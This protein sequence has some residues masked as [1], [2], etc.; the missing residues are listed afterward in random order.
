M[1]TEL[2]VP[3]GQN[4]QGILV[5]AA[6]AVRQTDYFCPQCGTP[7]V[8]RAGE[9]VIRHFAHKANTSC[10]GETIA[11]QTAKR[12]LVQIISEYSSPSC[13]KTISLSCPCSCCRKTTYLKLPSSSFTTAREE[14]RIGEFICDVVAFRDMEPVLGIEVLATHAVDEIK[15]DA[16]QIP[17]VELLAEKV[18]ENPYDWRPVAARLKEVTCIDCKN[19]I[20]KL[21][22]LANQWS[23]AF[24]E[25]ARSRSPLKDTY[26]AAIETCWKCRN[27]IL[28]YWWQGVPF[29][30]AEPPSPKPNT[31]QYRYSKNYRGEY[32]ANTC[33]HCEAVQGDN[34][35]FLGSKALFAG[36]PVRETPEMKA[37]RLSAGHQLVNHMLRNIG[38]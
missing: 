27:E 23:Q 30:E 7:L 11:H 21:K 26:H 4:P 33:P 24:H 14:H 5:S 20:A 29:A 25:P 16:L 8:L 34:F 37:Q 9:S 28:V 2:L 6:D 18:L 35:L 12:L 15:A 17:W 1:D 19:H 3:Y 32:W 13:Q 38:G 31:I 36:F 22:K 10:T